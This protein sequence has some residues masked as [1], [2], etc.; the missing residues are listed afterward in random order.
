LWLKNNLGPFLSSPAFANSLVILTFDEGQPTDL[1]HGGG[2]V[3][4]L[5]ISPKSKV[6][7]KSTTFYQHESTL[8]LMM[9]VLGV[10]DF[11]G[12]SASAPDMG[13]FFQ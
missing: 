2:R 10:T 6:G 13:E 5:I 11:P 3:S 8:R 9:K 7:Y 4:T 1:A 12:A